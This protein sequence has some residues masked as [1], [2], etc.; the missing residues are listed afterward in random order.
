MVDSQVVAF[1]FVAAVLTLTPG[2]DT[3]LV[4]RNV[5]RGGRH[6][7]M[8]TTCGMCAGLFVHAT[9]SALGVSVIL[10]HSAIC[11]HAYSKPLRRP[12]AVTA[13]VAP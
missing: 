1:T 4:V 5:L 13:A 12:A 9:L 8:V 3:M 6:H 10:M 11:V 2:A 7:G